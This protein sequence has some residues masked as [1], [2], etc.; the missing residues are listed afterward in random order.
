M[1]SH[2][3]AWQNVVGLLIF[4]VMCGFIAYAG[5][6]LGRRMG[7][8][9]LSIMGLRPRYT[10]IVMTTITGMLIAMFTI[11]VMAF[12]S[13]SVRLL[14]L[15]GIQIVSERKQIESQLQ[16]VHRSYDD[17]TRQLK[18]QQ[19]LAEDAKRDARIANRERLVL[20][21]EISIISHN[22]STLRATLRKNKLAL[23]Q[24]EKRLASAKGDVKAARREVESRRRIILA[25]TR[26]ID[27]LKTQ[28]AKLT[29]DVGYALQRW[30][31]YVALRQRNIIFR[32]GDE[33]ERKIIPCA[34]PRSNIRKMVQALLDDADKHAKKEGAK[35]GDNGRAIQILPIKVV[36]TTPSSERFLAEE[37][38][39]DAVVDNI[40]SG[41]GS[42]VLRIISVGNSVEGEQALVN[43][44]PNYNRMVYRSGDEVASI[45]ID[46]RQARG[47]IFGQ[48][49]NFFRDAVRPAAIGKG[50][51][52][53]SGEDGQLSVGQIPGD[54]LFE[55]VDT[56]KASGRPV[57]VRAV[58]AT[59]VWS[60][61][62]LVLNLMVTGG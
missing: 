59:D 38:S 32:S 31:M 35:Q 42:V 12:T 51:I 14:F 4:V 33:V 20:R 19:Q 24:A 53:T 23:T 15:H 11:G 54:Q 34:E 10:A 28:K 39:I 61:N 30:P 37:T 8:H 43:F 22:L 5:D 27:E 41:S 6:L 25:Q 52:P 16:G 55:L 56:I 9:R 50:V 21:S 26:Q 17:A 44:V 62:S 29:E 36:G 49:V 60:G 48:M 40:A 58:S 47:T 18:A 7:K 13:Q 57:R 2:G 46:G 1:N 3:V 45:V